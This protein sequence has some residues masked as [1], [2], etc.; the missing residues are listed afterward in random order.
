MGTIINTYPQKHDDMKDFI[1]TA[2][3]GGT[4][5]T[6][7]LYRSI[8]IAFPFM[9]NND[10]LGFNSQIYHRKKM[11]SN[12]DSFHIHYIPMGSADGTVLI[13]YTWGWWNVGS[14]IPSTLP[15]SGT[16]T[17]TL[18]TTD[19]YKYKIFSIIENIAPPADE[20]YGSF[21]LCRIVRNGGTWSPAGVNANELCILDADLHVPIDRNGYLY[22]FSDTTP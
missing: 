5:F 20:D 14:E 17:L 8:G 9:A 10:V 22:E 4:A 3:T 11:G 18:A 16:A 13:D 1:T 21:F 2:L 7:R 19:Q 6:N 15:N 12:A